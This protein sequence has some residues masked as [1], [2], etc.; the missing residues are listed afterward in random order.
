MG[1][2]ERSSNGYSHNVHYRDARS[3][4]RRLVRVEKESVK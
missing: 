3:V 4:R 2:N 1:P